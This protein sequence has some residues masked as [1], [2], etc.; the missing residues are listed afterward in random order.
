[1]CVV[2]GAPAAPPKPTP[3]DLASALALIEQLRQENELLRH[4]ID[5]LCRRLFGRKSDK[6]DPRQLELALTQLGNIT[7]SPKDPVEMDSTEVVGKERAERPRRKPTGRRPL[8]KHLPRRRVVLEPNAAER[9]CVACGCEKAKIGE[10]VSEKLDYVPSSFEVVETVQPRLACP[11]CHEGVVSAKAPVQAVEKGLAAE[12]LLAHVVTAKYA[13]HLPLFRL[14]GMFAR[15]GVDIPRSTLS[16]WVGQVAA[17]LEPLSECL[18]AHVLRATYLQTDDTPV[19]MLG[20]KNE[21]IKARLWAYLDPIGRRVVYEATPTHEGDWPRQFLASFRGRLQADAYAG[22]DAIYATGRVIEIGCWAHTRRR[23]VD[24]LESDSR[25]GPMIALIRQLYQVERQL[26]SATVEARRQGREEQSRLV[27]E[28]IDTLRGTLETEVLPKSPLGG[29][30]RY[31]RNQRLAL[32]RFVDDGRVAIDNNAAE[33]QL[34]VVALGRK[35]WLFAGS[36]AGMRRAAILYSLVQSC[37]LV[38]VDPFLYFRDVLLR[39]A[40]HPHGLVH[41][42]L[43]DACAARLSTQV[44]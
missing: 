40:T 22:Y 43:P 34:R 21:S 18:R 2:T 36:M 14:E 11:K 13:D 41:E 42:L 25:A 4:K 1:L 20:E 26:T 38:G 31:L 39:V 5:V 27:L 12:G 33:S 29:A 10:A 8:P 30:L 44:A 19:T 35:N 28:E 23:F 15:H 6:V 24:A 37:R 17:A 32:G 3:T 9:T 16:D 7:G